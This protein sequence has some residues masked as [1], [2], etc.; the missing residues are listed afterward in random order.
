M[1]RKGKGSKPTKGQ[2]NFENTSHIGSPSISKKPNPVQ[3]HHARTI[4]LDYGDNNL[5]V[6][7]PV[8]SGSSKRETMADHEDHVE[9]I[10]ENQVSGEQS[11]FLFPIVDPDTMVQMKDIPPSTL[12]HFHGKVHEDPDS[13]LFEFDIMCRSYDYSTDAQKLILFPVTLKDSS[14][15]WFMG[16]GGNTITS[17]DQMKRVLLSKYQEYCKTRDMQ[18]EIFIIIQDDDETLED[19]LEIFLYIL[20]W[21]KLKLDSSTIRSLLL[22]G[23][24]D[25]ARNNLNLLGQGD[26]S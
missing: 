8:E 26:I 22:R 15:R 17:W 7:Q 25:N 20:Q 11:T 1:P 24:T 5:G 14:L 23:L 3:T 21:S 18:Y 6:V 4:H 12:P 13:F 2:K 9:R 19:N 10:D 16:L